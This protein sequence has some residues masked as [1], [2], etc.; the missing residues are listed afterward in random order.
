MSVTSVE[1]DFD[2]L[3]LT[4]IA[5]FDAEVEQVWE[6]WADPRKLE[7]WWG[8]PRYPATFESYDLSPGSEI[9]Y[10]MTGPEG[11][12]HYGWWR[13]T[14]V[15]A[16]RLLEFSDGFAD[17]NGKPL[18]DP[19]SGTVRVRLSE[20]EGGTR[21]EMLSMNDSKEQLE[22]LDEMGMTQGLTEAVGQMDALLDA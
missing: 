22:E 18:A 21:M 17:E 19:P 15:E 10:F 14:A 12:K 1:K 11:D 2:H 13:I 6:L 4:L 16:P 8:P 20:H 7:R 5:D 9:I 3:R